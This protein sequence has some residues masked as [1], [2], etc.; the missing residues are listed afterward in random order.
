MRV[1]A[2][3]PSTAKDSTRILIVD[4]DPSTRFVLR[5]VL[6]REGYLVLEASDGGKALEMLEADPLPDV[7]AA[8]LM[9][10]MVSGFQLIERLRSEPR[11]LAIPIVVV[12]SN[13]DAAPR[14]SS[15]GMVD[16]I[17]S[18]PFTASDLTRGIYDVKDRRMRQ[19]S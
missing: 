5:L 10:P 11:T 13:P 14:L 12:T 18:K 1:L 2:D 9:M 7:V 17:V 16:A 4:D 6:E 3:S 8:D 19:A 15:S